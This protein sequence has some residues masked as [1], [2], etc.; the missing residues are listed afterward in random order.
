MRRFGKVNFRPDVNSD[1]TWAD[2]LGD[3]FCDLPNADVYG[4]TINCFVDS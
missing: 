4:Y 1:L 3:A 2:I